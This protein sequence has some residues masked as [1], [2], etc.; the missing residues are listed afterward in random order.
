MPAVPHL[1]AYVLDGKSLFIKAKT[2]IGMGVLAQIRICFIL[3]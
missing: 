2:P 1:Q 3:P